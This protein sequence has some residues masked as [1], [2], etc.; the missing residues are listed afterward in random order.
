MKKKEK[1]REKSNKK[2]LATPSWCLLFLQAQSGY[3][4]A[5]FC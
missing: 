4:W 2:R 3:C 1:W 5:A